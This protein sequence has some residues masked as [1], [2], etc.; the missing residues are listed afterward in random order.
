MGIIFNNLS[1]KIIAEPS[2]DTDIS[3]YIFMGE[4][5]TSVVLPRELY[6][7]LKKRAVKEGKTV[8]EA[9]IDAILNYLASK[10]EA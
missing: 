1:L 10:R 9:I 5:K 4:I 8:K 7:K 6:T 3:K 2:V